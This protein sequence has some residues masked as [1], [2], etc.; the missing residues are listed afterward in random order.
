MAVSQVSSYLFHDIA[1]QGHQPAVHTVNPGLARHSPAGELGI[2]EIADHIIQVGVLDLVHVRYLHK[3]VYRL[4]DIRI[5]RLVYFGLALIDTAP[6]Y[7][8]G[9]GFLFLLL[10][11]GDLACQVGNLFLQPAYIFSWLPDG[12]VLYGIDRFGNGRIIPVF[13]YGT[14]V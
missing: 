10:Q 4:L 9:C 13:M 3:L 1:A 11:R 5:H 12:I 14:T 2:I 8:Y 7:G 6:S